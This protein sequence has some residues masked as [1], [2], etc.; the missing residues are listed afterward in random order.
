MSR[1]VG[2]DGWDD[3]VVGAGSAGAVIAGRL[4]ECPDRRVLLLEAGRSVEPDPMDAR[5][6]GHPVLSGANWNHVAFL[7]PSPGE[8]RQLAYPVGK[9]VGGSSAINSA[10]ALRALPVDFEDWSATAGADWSWSRVAPYFA[11]LEADADI[12]GP[13]HGVDGPIPVRRPERLD[14]TALAFVAACQEM[15]LPDLADLN[16]DPGVGVG[17]VPS[18]SRQGRRVSTADAYLA[19]ARS[20]ANLIVRERSRVMRVLMA[21]GRAV[22]VEALVDGR[23][24]RVLADRVTLCAGAIG[25]PGILERSGIGSAERLRALG[26]SPVADLR[27]VGEN[28]TDHPVV[29]FWALPR[30][31][32]RPGIGPLHTVMARAASAGTD[33]APDTGVFLATDVVDIAVPV[34]RAALNG[35]RAV[36]VSVALLAPISRG[37]VHLAGSSA[38]AE[39]SIALSLVSEEAD[40]AA[41]RWGARLAW[42]LMRSTPMARL[43][44][45]VFIWTD[46]M[47]WDD[48]LIGPAIRRFV[49][50]M[51]HPVGTARMGRANDAMAVVDER[52]RVHEVSGLNVVDASVMP[53]IP[54]ATPNL[55]CVMIA[56]RVAEWLS[57][58]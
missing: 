45:R 29:V 39:P 30:M 9:A 34:V 19:P 48:I 2:P 40:L 4:S 52:C 54:R 27:G 28:L 42:T 6:V 58:A 44:D 3:V 7:G 50:P 53:V 35:R 18:N 14:D 25:T 17:L 12:A 51:F 33:D 26:I 41:L 55:T 11:K 10:I 38:D 5:P 16:G 20:R 47:M 15:A 57:Q 21:G 13:A 22:G 43:L 32:S 37:S 31:Q 56:E 24:V 8:G 49:A 23:P 36:S 1:D 46:R